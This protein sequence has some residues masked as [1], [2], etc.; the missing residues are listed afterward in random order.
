MDAHREAEIEHRLAALDISASATLRDIRLRTLMKAGNYAGVAEAMVRKR[1]NPI[2]LD[3]LRYYQ[4]GR[5]LLSSSETSD[6]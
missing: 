4:D 5:A 3:R 2:R 1:S 6:K